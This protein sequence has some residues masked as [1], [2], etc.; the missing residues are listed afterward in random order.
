MV[1]DLLEHLPGDD[2][3]KEEGL[4]FITSE[5]VRGYDAGLWQALRDESLPTDD[6]SE[7]GRSFFAFRTLAGSPLGYGGFER[8]GTHVLVRSLVVLPAQRGRGVGRNMLAILL[9]RAFDAGGRTA[10][11]LTTTAAAFFEATG[12]S[13][14]ARE[15]APSAILESRQAATLC[16]V[17][18]VLMSKRISL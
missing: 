2:V 5:P 16:P 14:S 9:R 4:P 1:I 10:W 17:S 11:L 15:L 6:L 12:F 13:S 18:A 7:P 8:Y 3:L